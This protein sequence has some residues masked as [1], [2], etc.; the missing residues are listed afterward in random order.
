MTVS[1]QRTRRRLLAGGIAAALVAATGLPVQA[2]G[3]RGGHITAGL[4]AEGFNIAKL[5]ATGQTLT[6]ISGDGSLIPGLA[7]HWSSADGARTWVFDLD[8]DA[9][10]AQEVLERFGAVEF[11]GK[12]ATVRLANPVENLPIQLASPYL[13]VPGAEGLYKAVKACSDELRLKRTSPHWKDA[14][15]GWFDAVTLVHIDNP[16]GRLAALRSGRVDVIDGLDSH[17]RRMLTGR[18][19][20]TVRGDLAATTKVG[21][22]QSIGSVWPLDNGRMAERWWIG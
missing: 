20:M 21:L 13:S 15:C 14:R 18:A 22:P 8:R 11:D 16:A 1:A 10:G 12:Q 17:A 5:G 7:S 9:R 19:D 6:E 4:T 3:R 2:M